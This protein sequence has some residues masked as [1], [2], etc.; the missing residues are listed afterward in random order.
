MRTRS[1]MAWARARARA[2]LSCLCLLLLAAPG[3]PGRAGECAGA[4]A[5][6]RYPLPLFPPSGLAGGLRTQFPARA[7]PP[8]PFS[9][10]AARIGPPSSFPLPRARP[11]PGGQLGGGVCGL[12]AP[13]PS[14]EL[15][16]PGLAPR[17]SRWG[18]R[19]PPP[20]PFPLPEQGILPGCPRLPPPMQGDFPLCGQH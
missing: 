3:Q 4:G 1:A 5:C 16:G 8:D 17:A 9:G 6:R 7:A 2:A 14:S 20:S 15:P 18:G 13:V 11:G 12:A 19:H 10:P